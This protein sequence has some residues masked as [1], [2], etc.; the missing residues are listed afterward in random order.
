MA[1]SPANLAVVTRTTLWICVLLSAVAPVHA[2]SRPIS[3]ADQVYPVFEK[4]R[5][6]MCHNPEGV[7]SPTR[8]RFP[9][10]G[11]AKDRIEAFGKSLVT[12]V[13]RRNPDGSIL[14][15]K[16]TNRVVHSG[17]A[18]VAR[19]SSEEALLKQWVVYLAS[20]HGE[21]LERALSYNRSEA[22]R[23]ARQ[24]TPHAVLRRLS[25][26]QYNN[27]IRD[28]LQ[29]PSSPADQFPAEDFVNGFK[30]QYQSQ[31]LS[32]VQAEAYS[33]AAERVA[34][35]AFRRGDSRHLIP[36]SPDDAGCRRTFVETIGRRA[37]RRPLEAEEIARLEALFQRQSGF[38][39]G[40]QAV[41]ETILQSPSFLFWMEQTSKPGWQP[42]A[43]ASRL[44]YCI[45][46]TMPDD[47]LLESA[48]RGELNS[49]GG[50]TRAARRMLDDPRA[51]QGLDDFVSQWLRFDRALAA[52]RDRRLFK[53][54]SQDVAIAMTEE[55]RRFIAD[56]VWNDRNFMDAFTANY[57]FM[58]SDL[59]A[60]YHVP[61]PARDFDR[62]EFPA[63]QQR[64]GL[65]GQALFLT[66]TSK[67]D[68]T[69][70]T[71]R[72]LFVRE[73]FLCQHVPPPPPGVDT[74]LAAVQQTHPVTNRERLAEHTANKVCAGCHQLIDPIG[75]GLEKFDAIGMY[76]E[77]QKLT[78]Y[79][80]LHGAAARRA[81]PVEIELA[82]DTAGQLAGLPQPQFSGARELGQLLA[83]T[84]QCQEC[85]VKQVFRYFS[86]RLDTP[87]DQ[88]MIRRAVEV[89]QKSGFHYKDM[90]VSL[91]EQ[92]NFS[93]AERMA[94]A[95][96]RQ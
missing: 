16:P 69:S 85:I 12:L 23:F 80:D 70:P 57:G 5:C 71:G 92:W 7:A 18:R 36:C 4:A 96:S 89:F 24:G 13:D 2:A 58:N 3:F 11:A 60:L 65:L 20:L 49:P 22:A 43:V 33:A 86:G 64:A 95:A 42:Y 25:H 47:A 62:V 83:N 94:D 88:A 56:L 72:G 9:E 82:L 63:E 53:L 26:Q 48:S 54:F 1:F 15:Q 66:L 39:A 46:D 51:R 61:P 87:G 90:V 10:E 29:D 55:A 8:L 44:A 77:K 74:N 45:W 68:D 75:F 59:A 79:P 50:V 93:P 35:N 30:N 21:D 14:L 78:F 41:I 84:P 32:P 19:G 91:L 73:Q 37:F 38:L 40:A 28:L 27:T 6:R 17:G 52:A 34:T 67:L 81:K 31:A 76:R